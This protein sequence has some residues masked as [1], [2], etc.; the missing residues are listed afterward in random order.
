MLII[1][2]PPRRRYS[3][4]ATLRRQITISPC[5]RCR[6]HYYDAAF[7]LIFA[8]YAIMLYADAY[9]DAIIFITV[10]AFDDA[11]YAAIDTISLSITPLRH[12]FITSC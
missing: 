2:T 10:F 4:I 8:D 6:C 11:R 1:I 5:L 7:D 12:A 3:L 9:A